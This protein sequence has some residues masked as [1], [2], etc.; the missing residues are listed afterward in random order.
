MLEN[1]NRSSAFVDRR[2][3]ETDTH[4]T[5]EEKALERFTAERQS[6]LAA[7]SKKAKFNLEDDDDDEGDGERD[8]LT[9]GGRKLGFG[10]E[11]VLGDSGWG[12][13]L[14]TQTPMFGRSR[15]AQ[16]PEDEVRQWRLG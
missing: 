16:E 2:F 10:D 15:E 11:D 12:G 1:R 6:R 9:H 3:G 7:P 8:A 14:A 13:M 5:P 4:M